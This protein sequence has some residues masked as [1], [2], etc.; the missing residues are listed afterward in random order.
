M[1]I[2]ITEF[3]ALKFESALLNQES[4]LEVLTECFFV[5]ELFQNLAKKLSYFFSDKN[6]VP[7]LLR[8]YHST[9]IDLVE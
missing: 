8:R 3:E 1:D 5:K 6:N 7:Y 9:I 2:L 4:E